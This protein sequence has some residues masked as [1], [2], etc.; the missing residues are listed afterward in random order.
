MKYTSQHLFE[1]DAFVDAEGR[2]ANY[3]LHG[4]MTIDTGSYQNDC[5]FG[6]RRLQQML[7]EQG[8]KIINLEIKEIGIV[9]LLKI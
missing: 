2:C 3:W 1:Y 5:F 4:Y 9:D 7:E 8:E 6:K